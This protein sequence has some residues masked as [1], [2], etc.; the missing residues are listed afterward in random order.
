MKT[1]NKI[2]YYIICIYTLFDTAELMDNND[3]YCNDNNS[4]YNRL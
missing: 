4:Y 2:K 3:T 1:A